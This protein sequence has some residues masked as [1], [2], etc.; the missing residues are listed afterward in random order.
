MWK[1]G[2][3]GRAWRLFRDRG[4]GSTLSHAQR[5]LRDRLLLERANRK[6]DAQLPLD[7]GVQHP[8]DE[9]T[10]NSAN[11]HLGEPYEATPAAFLPIVLR[12]LP[13]TLRN[14]VFV[15][16]GSGKGRVL[17]LAAGGP[18]SR[19]VGVEFAEELHRAAVANVAHAG[20][21]HRVSLTLGD[22]AEFPIPDKPCVLYFYNPF[23]RSVLEAVA[24]NIH[25]S[26]ERN[27]RPMYVIYYNPR[28][29]D[30]FER[31][32]FLTARPLR[33]L[34]RLQHRSLGV[35]DVRTYATA[36]AT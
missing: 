13:R 14:S 12:S 26:Y 35:A 15:D 21:E 1:A 5:R 7:T 4:L 24:A 27:P 23:D 17:L 25:R 11:L 6:L 18:F 30:V 20:L 16:F 36:E 3:I 33:L 8:L 22:A 32:G 19:L 10:V 31:S 2:D 9:L 34:Q 29:A 28:H